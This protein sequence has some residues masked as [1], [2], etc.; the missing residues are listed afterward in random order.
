[1]IFIDKTVSGPV[2]TKALCVFNVE[3]AD[4]TKKNQSVISVLHLKE[5]ATALVLKCGFLSP[6]DSHKKQKTC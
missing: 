5:N 2:F 1:M 4:E 3:K 6:N